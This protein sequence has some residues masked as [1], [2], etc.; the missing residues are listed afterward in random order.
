MHI[1]HSKSK[2]TDGLL[3]SKS[4][5]KYDNIYN[6]R[7]LA[8][9]AEIENY[10][11]TS[12]HITQH[13]KIQNSKQQREHKNNSKL[14]PVKGKCTINKQDLMLAYPIKYCK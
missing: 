8:I 4:P 9:L 5:L 2:C 10:H 13:I 14:I 7:D 1:S 6:T 3:R 12:K 11:A